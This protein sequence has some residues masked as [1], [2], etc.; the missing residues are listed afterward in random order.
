MRF[1][2]LFW[3]SE[4]W[5]EGLFRNSAVYKHFTYKW[6]WCNQK[7]FSYS[8]NPFFLNPT[9]EFSAPAVLWW[10]PACWSIVS[11]AQSKAAQLN[12]VFRKGPPL[13]LSRVLP[14]LRTLVLLCRSW[15]SRNQA[16]RS[17]SSL[18]GSSSGTVPL[19]SGWPAP[20]NKS[21][22]LLLPPSLA[23]V[24]HSPPL[25]FL[26]GRNEESYVQLQGAGDCLAWCGNC[27][28]PSSLP[29]LSLRQRLLMWLFSIPHASCLWLLPF[30]HISPRTS[31]DP[32]PAL[33]NF[34][35]VSSAG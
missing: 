30:R 7:N 11:S 29:M 20:W 5:G 27:P 14:P 22:L 26:P 17:C 13:V 3:D 1:Q 16:L 6:V 24:S 34:F 19:S 4:C 12:R 2:C 10:V 23:L 18:E 35:G 31:P 25:P 21:C 9:D 15:E 28:F 32:I 33:W 8:A